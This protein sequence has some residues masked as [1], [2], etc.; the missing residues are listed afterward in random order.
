[1]SEL[2]PYALN[3]IYAG[4]CRELVQSI[5]DGAVTLAFADPP[6]W[7]GFKYNGTTDR[8]MDYI[9]PLWLATE[10]ERIGNVAM[11]TPSIGHMYKYPEPRWVIAW[12]KPAA[13]GRNVAGGVNAWEPILLYGKG[14]I[15]IDVLTA[16]VS[17]QSDA[18]FHKCPK[19]LKLMTQIVN[20]FTKPND[21]VIDIMCGSAT[22]LVAAKRLGRRF[23]GFEIDPE[24]AELSRRR[25]ENTQPPLLTVDASTTPMLLELT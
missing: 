23:L 5:P 8:Q 13:M 11:I 25:L 12:H 7:V 20:Y 24:M 9:E 4:D 15:D 14:R 16:Q 22:T 3:S 17:A 10:L 1:M 21:I 18:A 19:P 6:Y 2:G